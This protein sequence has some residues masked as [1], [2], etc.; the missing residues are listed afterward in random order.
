MRERDWL[1][2][3]PFAH[4]GLHG[5]VGD[6]LENSLAA[7]RAAVRG[8]YGIEVDVQPSA[9]GVPMVFHDASLMRMTGRRGR[10]WQRP[11]DVLGALRLGETEDTIPTLDAVLAEVGGK[12]PLLVE[13]KQDAPD[14]IA[15]AD[16]VAARLGAYGGPAAAMS[17][18][19]AV[20]T[21]LARTAP[22]IARGFVS[23]DYKKV[24][25]L[26]LKE[27]QARARLD[28]L[29]TVP[30]DFVSY[31]VW[32]LP[33]PHVARRREQGVVVNAW[34]VRTPEDRAR[35]AA[36]ADTMTFEGFLP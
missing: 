16:A 13:I 21:H 10:T 9:D 29:D 22:D 1:R 17:F 33:S 20:V 4:R 18:S 35:A 27:K 2:A 12:V 34:T 15:L 19:P 26:T 7:V 24:R 8:G 6:G 23:Y 5:P 25:L 31:G 30:V 14:P 28:L 36:H 32:C 11:A 3:V